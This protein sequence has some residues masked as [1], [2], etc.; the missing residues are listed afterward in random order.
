MQSAKAPRSGTRDHPT[1]S[2][3]PHREAAIGALLYLILFMLIFRFVNLFGAEKVGLI[4]QKK[5]GTG[6]LSNST[7]NASESIGNYKYFS[8]AIVQFNHFSFFDSK[9]PIILEG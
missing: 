6:F 2:R 9:T 4:N 7:L 1:I 8:K 5:L 3:H